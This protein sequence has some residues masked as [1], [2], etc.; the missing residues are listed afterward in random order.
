MSCNDAK[1]LSYGQYHAVVGEESVT[2]RIGSNPKDSQ[3]VL[4]IPHTHI[5]QVQ[6][7]FNDAAKLQSHLIG[8]EKIRKSTGLSEKVRNFT[9]EALT[10]MIAATIADINEASE[11]YG[12]P[13]ED[14]FCMLQVYTSQTS[15]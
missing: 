2:L 3:T 14:L 12:V 15:I 4:V 9:D 13:K 6:T 1:T 7:L 10:V 11:K 5:K 8:V